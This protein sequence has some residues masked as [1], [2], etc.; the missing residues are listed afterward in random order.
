VVLTP[1]TDKHVSLWQQAVDRTGI[2]PSPLGGPEFNTTTIRGWEK[3]L[4]FRGDSLVIPVARGETTHFRVVRSAVYTGVAMNSL[5]G[6]DGMSDRVWSDIA[7]LPRRCVIMLDVPEEYYGGKEE[8]WRALNFHPLER[9]AY[10]KISLPTSYDEWFLR[11]NV[12]RQ[13]IRRAQQSGLD[14]TFGGKELLTSFYELYLNSFERWQSRREAAQAHDYVRFER[15][16][17]SP[18]S[19]VQ[20]A[21]VRLENRVA[22]AAIFCCYARTA[23]YLY[24][25]VDFEYQRLRPNN[26][27][28]AE[29]IRYLID[30]GVGEYNLGTSL[31]L[32]ELERFKETLGSVRL[33][34]VTLCRDR[35]PRLRRLWR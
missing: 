1:F 5:L 6:A 33:V 9:I 26:L 25:G 23:G 19:R 27:L 4:L 11:H 16:F 7:E 12:R 17:Q 21:A 15:L 13:H 10:H 3:T 18:E 32:R 20:I 35:F 22:A 34:S 29:I 24:G 8:K 30:R 2:S 14:V 28:H 31:N